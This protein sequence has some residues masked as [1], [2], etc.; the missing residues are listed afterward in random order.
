MCNLYS[1]TKSQAAI[2]EFTRALRNLTGNLP[3][4]TGVFPDYPAPIFRK[5]GW[6]ARVVAWAVGHAGSTTIWRR[7]YYKY[8][9][10]QERALTRMVETGTSLRRAVYVLL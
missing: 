4:M 2:I 1:V 8:P 10:R 6:R 3:P 9:E 5:A 7:A